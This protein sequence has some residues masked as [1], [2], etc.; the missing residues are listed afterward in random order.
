MNLADLFTWTN[1]AIFDDLGSHTIAAQHRDLQRRF[2]DLEL[3]IAFLG[4]GQ[5]DQLSVPREI[6]ALSRYELREIRGKLDG[7]YRVATDISTRAH[8]DDLRSRIDTGLRPG[9]LRPL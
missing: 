3:Q 5:M 7:A 6:Q 9:A 2:I 4:S 1:G 8:L